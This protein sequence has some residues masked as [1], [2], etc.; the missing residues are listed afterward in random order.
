MALQLLHLIPMPGTALLRFT[1]SRV[2]FLLQA[3]GRLPLALDFPQCPGFGASQPFL[4]LRAVGTQL[5]QFRGE[6]P[7]GR[8]E[9]LLQVVLAL[10][11]EPY[12]LLERRR[13]G[14]GDR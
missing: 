12:L 13:R 6:V 8:L 5:V 1:G 3:S 4:R 7:S 11:R 14:D 2:Q 9:R 10:L